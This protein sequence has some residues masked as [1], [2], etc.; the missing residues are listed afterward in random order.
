M[1]AIDAD[2]PVCTVIVTVDAGADVMDDLAT[3]ARAGVEDHFR[4]YPGFIA[5]ALHISRDGTR[6]VQYLQWASEADYL[7]CRDDH[8]WSSVDSTR[9]FMD[10]VERG[11]ATVDA[12]VYA[13]TATS[14]TR[15]G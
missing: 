13:I 5:G 11:R 2:R 15:L 1:I 14:A 3:H 7:R 10:L 12:R 4:R 9:R 6:L 8:R